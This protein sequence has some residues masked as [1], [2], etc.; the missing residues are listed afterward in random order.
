MTSVRVQESAAL[1]IDE[2]YRN[3]RDRWGTVQASVYVGGLFEAFDRIA[4]GGVP[5]RPIP[6]E[7]G[8][9]GYVFS[10]RKALRVLETARRRGHRNRHGSA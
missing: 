8:V 5:S 7:F 10:V 1:R 3:T 9:D 6:A 4:I 2:I